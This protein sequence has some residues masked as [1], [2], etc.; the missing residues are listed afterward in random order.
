MRETEIT[1]PVSGRTVQIRRPPVSMASLTLD[2]RARFP[3][4][5]PPLQEVKI[6]GKSEWVENIAH[7]DYPR[8][9]QEW[10]NT[11]NAK[12]AEAMLRF[13]VVTEPDEAD[14]EAIARLREALGDLLAGASDRDVFIRHILIESDEDFA[15]LSDAIAELS[16]PTEA[17]IADHTARFRRAS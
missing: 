4:P 2:F 10:N 5:R 7:P 13:G 16:M 1:L 15:V 3:K 8:A 9:L 14:L 12:L 17:Q 6:M 11:L